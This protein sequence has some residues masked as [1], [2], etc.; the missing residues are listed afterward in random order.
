VTAGR[1]PFVVPG[2]DHRKFLRKGQDLQ[3]E[4]GATTAQASQ[5]NQPR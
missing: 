5:G 1:E 2:G 4:E 3:M